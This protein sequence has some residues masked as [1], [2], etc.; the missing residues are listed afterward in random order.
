[1]G[2]TFSYSPTQQFFLA[3]DM[4]LKH[5]LST[6]EQGTRC[7]TKEIQSSFKGIQQCNEIITQSKPTG[8][9]GGNINE[10]YPH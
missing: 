9:G 10:I 4:D 5:E 8:K 7:C 2:F 1:M 3:Q 6:S